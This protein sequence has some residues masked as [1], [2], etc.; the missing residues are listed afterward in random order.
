MRRLTYRF[1]K[2]IKDDSSL[3][4]APMCPEKGVGYIWRMRNDRIYRMVPIIGVRSQLVNV[5]VYFGRYCRTVGDLPRAWPP[6][7]HCRLAYRLEPYISKANIV[8]YC[9]GNHEI[10]CN[11]HAS[12]SRFLLKKM[13]NCLTTFLYTLSQ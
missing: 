11:M 13:A 5:L 4:G 12:F 9:N 2:L 8:L 3:S 6:K 10:H 7:S 1:L